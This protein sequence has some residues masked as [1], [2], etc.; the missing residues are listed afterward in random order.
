MKHRILIVEDN[1]MLAGQ[2]K[3]WLEKSGY[4]VQTTIDELGARKRIKSEHFDLILTDVRKETAYPCLNGCTR[5][6]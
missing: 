1:I 2:Q 4:E 5:K 6:R 3:K